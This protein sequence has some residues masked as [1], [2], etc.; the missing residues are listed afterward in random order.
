MDIE[1]DFMDVE[2]PI[3]VKEILVM[4]EFIEYKNTQLPILKNTIPG[5]KYKEY[6]AILVSRWIQ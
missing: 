5:L 4:P 6:I 3:T 2:K 1:S